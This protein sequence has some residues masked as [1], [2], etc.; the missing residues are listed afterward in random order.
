MI[1]MVFK[2][3]WILNV[4]SCIYPFQSC[5]IVLVESFGLFFLNDCVEFFLHVV[6]RVGICFG[7]GLRVSFVASDVAYI[8]KL[9]VLLNLWKMQVLL[10]MASN[11]DESRYWWHDLQPCSLQGECCCQP[12]GNL[13]FNGVVE[14]CWC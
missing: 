2:V 4:K 6:R 5:L 9:S 3:A 11:L 8:I 10:L 12:V 1:D 13:G 7:C 14:L